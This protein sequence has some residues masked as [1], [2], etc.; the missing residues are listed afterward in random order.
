MATVKINKSTIEAVTPPDKGYL[1]VW[2][3]VIRGF[4][5]RVTASGIRSYILQVRIKGRE[6]RI[7]VGRYPGVSPEVARKV[8]QGMLGQIAEGGDPVAEKAKRKLESVTLEEAFKEYTEHRRRRKDK[9]PLKERT[10]SDMLRTLDET[11]AD[12]KRQAVVK[13]TRDMVRRRY[14]ERAAKSVARTNL[15]FRYLS[16]VLN[17][18]MA[19]YRDAEGRP[20]LT[21]NPVRVLSEASVWRGV[22]ARTSVLTPDNLK[23]WVPAV[24]ALG[25]VPDRKE[26]QGKSR[27]KLRN[28]E[29]FRDFFM[30]LILTGCRKG[31]AQGLCKH[32][33]DF[34][35]D[36]FVFEDT[37]NRTDHELPMTPYVRALLKRRV[38]AA[39]KDLIFVSPHDGRAI[40]NMRNVTARLQTD[41]GLTFTPHDLRRTVATTLERIAVPA[42]TIKALLNHLPGAHDVT[43]RYTQVDLDMK[44]TALEKLETF[45]LGYAPQVNAERH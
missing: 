44:R 31:E 6:K 40:T 16:A 18:F 41:T 5:L 8:A 29:V 2:D 14:Q 26:G 34:K 36:V 35:R 4:G 9:K 43:G 3:E 15:A 32:T 25:D 42:Y 24:L 22:D 12:W 7:T 21:D 28:G 13:I 10:R 1:L 11:F 17:F 38:K 27:P 30:L 33:I 19:T 39:E 20:V 37:K 23:L 45:I